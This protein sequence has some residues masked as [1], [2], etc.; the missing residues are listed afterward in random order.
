MKHTANSSSALI[1]RH[2]A[3]KWRSVAPSDGPRVS[4]DGLTSSS[5]VQWLSTDALN[6]STD[7]LFLSSGGIKVE[8][9][10]LLK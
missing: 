2:P 7:V 1:R 9:G 10:S 6:L 8:H 3:L 4:S 5:G